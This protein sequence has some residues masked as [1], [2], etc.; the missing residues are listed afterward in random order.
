MRHGKKILLLGANGMLGHTVLKYLRREHDVLPFDSTGFNILK[1]PISDLGQILSTVDTIVNCVGIIKPRI[2][3]YTPEEVLRV[4]SIFPMALYRYIDNQADTE[5]ELDWETFPPIIHIS[6]DCVFS[7]KNGP[8]SEKDVPDATD[9][10]GI[11]KFFGEYKH[12]TNIRTSIIGEEVNNKYSLL[13]WAKTQSGKT[14]SGYTDHLWSGITTLELAKFI[15]FMIDEDYDDMSGLT[16]VV[17]DTVSKYELLNIINNIYDLH[18]DIKKVDS[19]TPINRSLIKS[20]RGWIEEFKI[21]PLE[22]QLTELKEFCN[23]C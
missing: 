2:H 23:E 4:N 15:E 20:D 5:E 14:I 12:N 13:E 21:K 10:Y 17:G 22:Q 3:M 9:L 11:S 16:H 18:I 1:Q 7:G 6:S 8:Y 19:G